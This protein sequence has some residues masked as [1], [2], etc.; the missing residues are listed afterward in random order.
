MPTHPTIRIE[1]NGTPREV[2]ADTTVAEL[3]RE[4]GL[5]P[6]VVATEVNRALVKRA[7]RDG[8]ALRDGDAVEVVT[9]VGGG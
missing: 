4:L 6:E 5:R 8:R 9:L 1:W 2:R 3:V 7:D